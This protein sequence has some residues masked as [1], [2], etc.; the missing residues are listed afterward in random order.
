MAAVIGYSNLIDTATLGGTFAGTANLKTRYLAQK[1]TAGTSAYL[2]IDVGTAQSLGV[3]AVIAH[4]GTVGTVRVRGGTT[5]GGSNKYDSGVQS[6]YTG[7]DFALPF[8]PAAA[9]Y[10]RIDVTGSSIAIGRVFLGYRFRPAVNVDWN[11]TL[12]VESRTGVVE[13]LSGMEYF[14]E[15]PNR[16]VWR[17]VFGWL[18]PAEAAEWL[19]VQRNLDVSREVYWIEDDAD[20]T[21]RADRWFLGR[22]RTLS[23]I[24]YP[25]LSVH[26]TAVEIGE[27]L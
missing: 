11:P 12:E 27:L 9:R 2:D 21:Y 26:R 14:D 7:N 5:V 18:T 23:A 25:Y 6:V 20:T 24:E 17:G 13:S 1:A 10:W 3:A 16:R 15:R 4:G 8:T 22:L 19:A